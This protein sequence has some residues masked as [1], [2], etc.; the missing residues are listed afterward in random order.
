[1]GQWGEGGANGQWAACDEYELSGDEIVAKV[2]YDENLQ[3]WRLYTPLEDAP[4]LFLKFV[5]LHEA[6]NFEEA[7]LHFSRRYGLLH[8]YRQ[9]RGDLFKLRHEAKQVWVVLMLYEAVLSRDVQAVRLLVHQGAD[10]IPELIT[11]F[12]NFEGLIDIGYFREGSKVTLVSFALGATKVLVEQRVSEL[13]YLTLDYKSLPLS[14][15]PSQIRSAV[16]FRN[17]LGAMYLQMYWL[18]AS[19]GDI[20]RCEYCGRV[21]SLARPHPEGRKRRRDKK[22]CDDACR[23]AHHRARKKS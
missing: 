5:R 14:S 12:E 8:H 20:A 21:I 13:C 6:A 19:G 7:A 16:G 18:M 10:A 3:P 11:Y 15:D 4:D 2:H 1:M 23:Q 17:L 9:L 22:T